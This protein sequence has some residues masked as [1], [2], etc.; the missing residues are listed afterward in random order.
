L[1][2]GHSLSH[3]CLY[4]QTHIKPSPR[5]RWSLILAQE[6]RVSMSSVSG[7][8]PALIRVL[9]SSVAIA[10]KAGDIVRNIFSAGQLGIVEKTGAD[11]LQTQ[12]DRSAQDCILASLFTQY[13]DLKVVGEEGE[14][15]MSSV[16]KN[17]VVRDVDQSAL[18]LPCPAEWQG[19]G[20]GDLTVWVDPLD[21]TKEYTQGLLD[22]VTV[23][24][25]IAVG[26]KA[27]AG[28]IHQ[29]YYNY[30][31]EGAPVGRTFYGLV[32]A[33]VHGLTRV[34]P[35][36]DQRIVTTTRSHGTGLVQEALDILKPD[37]VLKVGGAGHKVLLLMEG[38]ASAY[39]FPSPG[40]KKWDTCAP[41]AILHAMGGKLTDIHGDDYEYH[42][43]VQHQNMEGVLATA[44]SD[45]HALYVAEL[46]QS[47][48]EQVKHS[49]KKTK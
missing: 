1:L 21:G 38:Q 42:S 31:T 46:P 13:P 33:G 43:E 44:R 15:E 36:V 30:K 10:D 48:K 26:S 34:L 45:I 20:M 14:L 32:G 5:L 41:E 29:P 40:C 39:V 2:S 28:V 8:P 37:K 17:M 19:A 9:A 23:L 16:D 4:T 27:V 18:K 11:D 35:P 22:H 25:G 24:I 47:L 12:A 7:Q 49:L 6:P 3:S